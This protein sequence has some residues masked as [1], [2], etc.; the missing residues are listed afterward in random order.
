MNSI[1]FRHNN[2][3]SDIR[4]LMKGAIKYDLCHN[5]RALL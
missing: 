2:N 4:V 5:Y 1:I 3:T